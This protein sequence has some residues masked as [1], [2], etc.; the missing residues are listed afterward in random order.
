M[1]FCDP[2]YFVCLLPLTAIVYWLAI[3]KHKTGWTVPVL[4]VASTVF[5]ITWNW[6][7]FFLLLASAS[8]NFCIGNSLL[9]KNRRTVLLMLGVSANVALLGY[10]KYYNFFIENCN[11]LLG[12]HWALANIILPLGISF[13]TFQQ[14]AYLVDAYKHLAA[15]C[16]FLEYVL[17]VIFFPQLI[18]GPIVHYQEMIPQFKAQKTVN[19]E[20]MYQGLSLFIFGLFKKVMLADTLAGY[21]NECYGSIDQLQFLGAWTAS[22]GYTLQLYFDFSG[23]ADMAIG[24]GL[25]FG[26]RL[27]DNFNSPYQA[28][29]I[30]DFWRRWHMTLSTWLK[31]YVYIPL[32]G[33]HCAL[34]RTCVNLFLTFLIGGIWH[35]AGWTFV[36]WGGLHG[37]A[38]VIHRLWTKTGYQLNT[39]L[40]WLITFNFV[41]IAWVF[42]RANS[43]QDACVI[44]KKMFNVFYIKSLINVDLP[45][46][47]VRVVKSEVWGALM[48]NLVAGRFII[49]VG[50]L[51]ALCVLFNNSKQ[52]CDR[53]LR[54]FW[55]KTVLLWGTFMFL[56]MHIVNKA[57][58][59]EFLYWQF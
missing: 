16:S 58:Q 29:S 1:L 9:K 50:I 19:W 25:L 57:S 44:L 13:Y 31:N 14:I 37:I 55:Y 8:V 3:A 20:A 51:L 34:S 26:I 5:Y 38:S 39:F 28:L 24:S 21:V 46:K 32:G 11:A 53:F 27:P 17:F 33:S 48:D 41:N 35:G 40:S 6:K 4:L 45:D 10:F 12:T 56:W 36:I 43:V 49:T 23:Y 42:F 15:P 52:L 2:W 47:I 7:F 30:Q 18:A 59:A 22:I 54:P